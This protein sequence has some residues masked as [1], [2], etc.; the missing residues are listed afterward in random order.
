MV[1][2]S[3]DRSGTEMEG[4]MK[5]DQRQQELLQIF[6]RKGTIW[7]P[8]H[9][10]YQMLA[11]IMIGISMLLCVMPYQMWE[12]PRDTPVSFLCNM[13][14][15]TGVLYYM[16]RYTNYAEGRKTKSVFDILRYLPVSRGQLQ[17]FII[18]KIIRLCGCLT[19][20]TI[21]CQTVFAVAFMHTF[22]IENV[23]LPVRFNFLLPVS[24]VLL[25]TSFHGR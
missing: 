6:Y 13:L 3:L 9:V 7:C 5:T 4:N 11:A 19:A 22:S 12:F 20:V 17:I 10:T 2:Q 21:C 14:Y 18:K 24:L 16:Q 23:F 25:F 1:Q 8:G 15:L